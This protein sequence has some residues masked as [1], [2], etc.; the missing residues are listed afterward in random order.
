MECFKK[1]K[2]SVLLSDYSGS[3]LCITTHRKKKKIPQTA[4][5]RTGNLGMIKYLQ[6]LY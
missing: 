2:K 3:V 6:L 5:I 1:K 4:D